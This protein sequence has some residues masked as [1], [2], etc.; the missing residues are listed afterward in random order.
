MVCKKEG[1]RMREEECTCRV[2]LDQV[3]TLQ[4][5]FTGGHKVERSTIV[6]RVG[7]AMYQ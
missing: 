4:I 7:E 3:L 5:S 1:M 2:S 6:S